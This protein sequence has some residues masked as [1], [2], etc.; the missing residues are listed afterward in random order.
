GKTTLMGI[1]GLLETPT[2]GTYWLGGQPAGDLGD[3]D[4]AAFRNKT[5]GFV[6]QQ[7]SLIPQ[8]NAWQNV[9]RPLSY[10]GVPKKERKARAMALLAEVGLEGRAEHRPGELSG[11]EQQR[12]AIARALVNDPA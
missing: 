8:L 10:A 11:G 4:R 5:F 9:A 3:R 2:S 6:F 1:L 12:V 7:F